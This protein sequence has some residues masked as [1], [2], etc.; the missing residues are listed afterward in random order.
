[1]KTCLEAL[2]H[3]SFSSLDSLKAYQENELY[4]TLLSTVHI[5]LNFNIIGNNL[6]GFQERDRT[7]I[8]FLFC[9]YMTL[10]ENGAFSFSGPT[11]SPS[12]SQFSH[13][14]LLHEDLPSLP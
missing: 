3:H 13:P 5:W 8:H 9:L 2:Q 10:C 4:V 6:S 14:S 1:M 11:H 7:S 12:L